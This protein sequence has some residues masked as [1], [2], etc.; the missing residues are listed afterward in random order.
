[1]LPGSVCVLSDSVV[2]FQVELC[3]FKESVCFQ[4]VL[5]VVR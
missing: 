4:V 2:C 5:C 3:V 1:V